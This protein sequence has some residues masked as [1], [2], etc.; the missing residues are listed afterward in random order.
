[1]Y[2]TVLSFINLDI[3]IVIQYM[4]IEKFKVDP[5]LSTLTFSFSKLKTEKMLRLLDIK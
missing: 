5:V 3:S 4:C 2:N 1:M